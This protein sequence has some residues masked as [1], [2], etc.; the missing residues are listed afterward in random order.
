[1]KKIDNSKIGL[2]FFILSGVFVLPLPSAAQSYAW[3]V[4]GQGEPLQAGGDFRGS[5][6]D[7]MDNILD[8]NLDNTNFEGS[9]F[10]DMVIQDTSF[11]GANL[12]SVDASLLNEAM[13]G[14][15]F[16]DA[17][18]TGSYLPL[19]GEQLRSTKNY[20]NKNLA[21]TTLWGD[22]SGVSFVGFDMTNT[23][24][25]GCNLINCDF[26]DAIITKIITNCMTFDQIK[27]T[28]NYKFKDLGGTVFIQRNF[29][30][31]DF[32]GFKLGAF[33]NCSFY[34]TDF[35]D[36]LFVKIRFRDDQ[37]RTEEFYEHRLGFVECQLTREQFE[38]TRTY[39]SKDLSWLLLTRMNLDQWNFRDCNLEGALLSRS[40]LKDADF[41]DAKIAQTNFSQTNV[42]QK[43]YLSTRTFSGK[44]QFMPPNTYHADLSN[45]DFSGMTIHDMNNRVYFSYVN[46]KNADFSNVTLVNVQFYECD[47]SDAN[48]TNAKLDGVYFDHTSLSWE[49]F[50]STQNGQARDFSKLNFTGTNFSGTRGWDFSNAD[51]TGIRW[52]PSA[53]PDCVFDNTTINVSNFLVPLMPQGP[54]G[55]TRDQF[56]STKNFRSKVLQNAQFHGLDLH[57]MD[58]SGFDLAGTNFSYANLADVRFADATI[59]GC[60]FNFSTRDNYTPLTKE[61]FYSTASYKSGTVSGVHFSDMDLTDW[62][63]S[64]VRL[65]NCWFN[66]CIGAPTQR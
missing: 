18:I 33:H 37:T 21:D 17:D 46:L 55:L 58:F 48:F 57:G 19:N 32:S 12:R 26:T 14:C 27:V 56:M 6:F 66:N 22:L 25:L 8:M 7:N 52:W 10:V 53:Y 65:G 45:Y 39:Q 49:Q 50:L 63:F 60:V 15:D 3:K 41:T 2:F 16:T 42:T 36:A 30:D 43:Q 23:K 35:S 9:R 38:S 47:L 59:D 11:R 5:E 54:Y 51:L 64:K 28:R 62:D 61:Q 34:N 24:L 4:G 29:D 31:A 13:T 1:M 20:K 40:S 44:K